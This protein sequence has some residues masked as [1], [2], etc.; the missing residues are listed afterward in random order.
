MIAKIYMILINKT[1]TYGPCAKCIHVTDAASASSDTFS[2]S[3]HVSMTADG[4]RKWRNTSAT[5]EEVGMN[6]FM[7]VFKRKYC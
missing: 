3:H 7:L 1:A 4:G 2:Q 5:L 6:C